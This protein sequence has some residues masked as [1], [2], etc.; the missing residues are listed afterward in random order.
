M[1]MSLLLVLTFELLAER[2]HIDDPSERGL[3]TC[4]G[5]ARL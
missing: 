3:S 5:H 2:L 4:T 1:V